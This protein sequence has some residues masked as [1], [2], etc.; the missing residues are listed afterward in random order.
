[1]SNVPARRSSADSPA[2]GSTGSVQ[3]AS[4][5][6]SGTG[7]GRAATSATYTGSGV[8][9]F[10]IEQLRIMVAVP[11]DELA[12]DVLF[13]VGEELVVR[14]NRKTDARRQTGQCWLLSS[15]AAIRVDVER[16]VEPAAGGQMRPAGKWRRDLGLQLRLRDVRRR[17]LDLGAMAS[18]GA[19]DPGPLTS[20]RHALD[21]ASNFMLLPTEARDIVE[22]EVPFSRH[23][24]RV[25]R[26]V[27]HDGTT[28]DVRYLR[29]DRGRLVAVA[30]T[31]ANNG[32]GHTGPWTVRLLA[33]TIVG[34]TDNRDL[35]A[36]SLPTP[37]NT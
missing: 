17:T 11:R 24:V 21:S 30:A 18:A 33:A 1:M 16:D 4:A 7:D 23:R 25:A 12:G 13:S 22:R 14:H 10:D 28:E 5:R 8:T 3:R 34:K 27:L 26:A 36:G 35:E 29:M 20:R 6:G 15:S 32:A 37:R 9:L 31:R 19:A 2:Q